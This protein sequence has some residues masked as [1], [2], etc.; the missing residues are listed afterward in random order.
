MNSVALYYKGTVKDGERTPREFKDLATVRNS[1]ETE[2]YDL[3]DNEKKIEEFI[4]SYPMLEDF[5]FHYC[6]V[7]LE[8]EYPN[9]DVV[10]VDP[11]N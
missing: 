4:L 1:T 11:D 3:P 5:Q 6:E 8:G 10:D 7:C 9:W 2:Y